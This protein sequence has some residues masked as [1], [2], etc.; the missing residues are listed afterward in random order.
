VNVM[1]SPPPRV[2]PSSILALTSVAAFRELIHEGSKTYGNY[3]SAVR[4]PND[5]YRAV[6]VVTLPD[7]TIPN[8]I[9]RLGHL[10]VAEWER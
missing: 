5:V 7:V 3:Y 6:S 4:F 1:A 8:L 9:G 2:P 10:E